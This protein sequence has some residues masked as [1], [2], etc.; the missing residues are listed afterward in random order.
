MLSGGRGE[1][2]VEWGHR[3]GRKERGGQEERGGQGTGDRGEDGRTGVEGG[4]GEDGGG[5]GQEGRTGV[6]EDRGE[7]GGGG[8]Y[9]CIPGLASFSSLSNSTLAFEPGLLNT[10]LVSRPIMEHISM[11]TM[12]M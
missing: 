1:G 5:G 6:E 8:G 7:D 11:T 9:V 4:R 10:P 3:G 2:L 12:R